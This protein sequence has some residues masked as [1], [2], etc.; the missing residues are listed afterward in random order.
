MAAASGAAG[1]LP[2]RLGTKKVFLPSHSITFLAPRPNQSPTFA[3]FK[4]PLT[5][6]KFDIRDYLL[7]AYNTPVLAVRSQVRQ[8]RDIMKHITGRK[9]RA[10]PIK[11]MTVQLTKP[12][13]WPSMP[14]D[15]RPWLLAASTR[16]TDEQTARRRM[17]MQ[18]RKTGVMPLRDERKESLD[19]KNLRKEAERLLKEGGWTNRRELDPRFSEKG[20]VKKS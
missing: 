9:F 16:A 20:N 6:N 11:T 14:T 18:I 19:R 2:F 10:P 12:F 3:T 13:V 1:A 4:V 7:H 17:T 5:F 8:R 15:T